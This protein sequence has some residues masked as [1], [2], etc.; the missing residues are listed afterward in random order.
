LSNTEFP[1]AVFSLRGGI[2]CQP[3]ALFPPE[4]YISVLFET[5][6]DDFQIPMVIPYSNPMSRPLLC[7]PQG[8]SPLRSLITN[9]RRIFEMRYTD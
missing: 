9:I 3:I 6:G 2:F 7:L 5:T 4:F 1:L 8:R